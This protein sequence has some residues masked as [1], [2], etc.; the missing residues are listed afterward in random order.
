HRDGP[1]RAGPELH[2]RRRFR[3]R[4]HGDGR[5]PPARQGR[6]RLPGAPARAPLGRLG[7]P[8][9]A[10]LWGAV[11]ATG[12]SW[13]FFTYAPGEMHFTDELHSY[14]YRVVEF[15]D[16]LADG[17]PFPQWAGDFPMG[18]GSPYFGYYQPGFFYVASTFATALSPTAAIGAT[19]WCFAL[20][21]Y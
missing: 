1:H 19:L 2:Q 10:W 18:L 16:C 13:C 8:V 17:H 7:A 14:V 15:R 5:V 3:P 11:V 12:L 21:G 20:L 4:R 6:L 9:L